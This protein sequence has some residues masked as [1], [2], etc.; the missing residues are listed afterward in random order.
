MKLK[1]GG[2]EDNTTEQ[3]RITLQREREKRN[4]RG[5]EERKRE[6]SKAKEHFGETKNNK[7]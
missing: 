4:Q 1:K 3:N 7:K 6:G 5:D 2:G